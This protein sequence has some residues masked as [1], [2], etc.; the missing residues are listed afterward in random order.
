MEPNEAHTFAFFDSDV[1]DCGGTPLSQTLDEGFT[2]DANGFGKLRSKFDNLTLTGEDSIVGKY[3][4][5]SNT[6][7]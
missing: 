7:G 3:L 1:A 2:S 4:Q 6:N 5:L